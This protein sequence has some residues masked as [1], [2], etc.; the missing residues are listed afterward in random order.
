MMSV[1]V[2]IQ[3]NYT[4]LATLTSI[5]NGRSVLELV[6][7]T[8][9]GIK[10]DSGSIAKPIVCGPPFFGCYEKVIYDC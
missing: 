5:K 3:S 1:L 8:Q 4:H 2:I 7:K 9:A 10:K 6:E